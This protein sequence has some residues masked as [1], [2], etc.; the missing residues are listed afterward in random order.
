[1]ISQ[2]IKK[3]RNLWSKEWVLKL[4]SLCLAV[5]LWYFVG[6]EDIVEKNVMV[7][8]E[9]IN[10]PNDLIISNKHKREIEVTVRG[11]R[12][13]ILE[14]GKDQAARQIDL[15]KATPGTKVERIENESVP[16]SRGV[17]VLRVQPSSIILSL[18]KLINKEFVINPVTIGSVT[19]GYV[20][21]DLRI[22]PSSIAITG[23]QTVLS[24]VDVLKTT[25]INIHGLFESIQLQIPLELDQALIDLIGETSVTADISIGY[26]TIEK[27]IKDVPVNV[28]T[29][30]FPREVDPATV[31]V[32]M[33]IPKMIIAEKMKLTDLFSVTAVEDKAGGGYNRLKVQVVPSSDLTVPL[34]IISIEPEY[35]TLVMTPSP[36]PEVSETTSV[37]EK[38]VETAQP[39]ISNKKPKTLNQKK[40]AE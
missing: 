19:P 12:S 8:V 15:A 16:V 1:M 24:Q 39:E 32:T 10:L 23:P 17:E 21:R 29:N 3:I 25:P 20:L 13:L 40:A 14:M 34:E 7:P 9:V 4:I 22:D 27:T 36:E 2:V 37:P 26:D 5:M 28:T 11:P 30:G 6:G 33:K 35:V 18:D 38:A 31:T